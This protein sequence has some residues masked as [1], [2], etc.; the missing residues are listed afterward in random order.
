MIILLYFIIAS[1]LIVFSVTLFNA[2]SAP[3][4]IR[5]PIPEKP[6]FVSLCVPAR[7]EAENIEGCL[8][9]LLRQDY[10][11]YEILVLDDESRDSTLQIIRAMARRHPRIRPFEGRPL[12][13]GWTG[14]NWACHQLSCKARGDLLIFTD[15][16]NRHAPL[17]VA[18][19]AGWM[20]K[21]NLDLF[22]AF[23]QQKMEPLS[24]K[25]VVPTVYMTVYS[26]LPLWLTYLLPFPSLA[27][28]NGQWLAFRRTAY[29]Q[30]HA[31]KA[32]A[33]E[34]VEDTWLARH[35]KRNGLKILTAAGTGAVTGRMYR[36]WREVREGFSKNLFGLMGYRSVPFLMLLAFMC[37]AYTGPYI[38]V[39][40]H[41]F[42][43]ISLLAILVNS[44]IRLTLILK[45]KDP[46]VTLV[47]HPVA[48]LL[49]VWIGIRSMTQTR[50]GRLTWK[51]RTLGEEGKG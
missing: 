38:L 46:P 26:Y 11:D 51:D 17:A 14:K 13:P 28:A 18:K 2:L 37:L 32:A 40:I 30:L 21:Y 39:W 49:T 4:L 31:H 6:P 16:D 1:L 24:E 19:T 35:A 43:V 36:S 9:S 15:A 3:M 25:L 42:Q 48:V 10:R 8:A 12:P 20:E 23:P 7:N 41:P 27:A 44:L 50:S 47:L 5:G 33:K 22:S 45:Y 34:P 29:E